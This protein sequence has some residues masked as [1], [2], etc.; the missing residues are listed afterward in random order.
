MSSSRI[1]LRLI[2]SRST[3][4]SFHVSAHRLPSASCSGVQSASAEDFFMHGSLARLTGSRRRDPA[5]DQYI[6]LL[7]IKQFAFND[8]NL[9][10]DHVAEVQLTAVSKSNVL[11]GV[12]ERSC[13]GGM[14]KRR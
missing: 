8:G 7:S 3:A 12:R 13:I 6:S 11:R 5:T 1:S 14:F 9:S 2:R 10:I 4:A